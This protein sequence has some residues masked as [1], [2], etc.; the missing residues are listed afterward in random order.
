MSERFRIATSHS[1]MELTGVLTRG[2]GFV[3]LALT[4][5]RTFVTRRAGPGSAAAAS[6]TER[7]R[8]AGSRRRSTEVE[9]ARRDVVDDRYGQRRAVGAADLAA[10]DVVDEVLAGAA[11]GGVAIQVL[12]EVDLARRRLD[13]PLL[14]ARTV[15]RPDVVSAPGV[16]GS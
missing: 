16:V 6:Q 9:P 11:E 7:S 1:A 13:E 2:F 15:R 3:R 5:T 12:P 10:E 14:D 8:S 4:V